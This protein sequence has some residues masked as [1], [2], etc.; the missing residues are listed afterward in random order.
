M[1]TLCWTSLGYKNH[2]SCKILPKFSSALHF[3][4]ESYKFVQESQ[5]LQICYNVEHF[6]H[7]SDNIFCKKCIFLVRN[8][9]KKC[10]LLIRPKLQKSSNYQQQQTQLPF[11]MHKLFHDPS[12]RLKIVNFE[13]EDFTCNFTPEI[14]ITYSSYE[15]PDKNSENSSANDD[16][17][18]NMI[19]IENTFQGGFLTVLTRTCCQLLSWRKSVK[20]LQ[21]HLCNVILKTIKTLIILA[22]FNHR[23]HFFSSPFQLVMR[24]LRME[25]IALSEALT[26][27]RALML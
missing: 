1:W 2:K 15:T 12:K 25:D 4:Q 13:Q 24:L 19:P 16:R 11:T 3:L 18:M 14:T 26:P 5:I 8:S 21:N 7:D 17:N 23:F 10:D 20:I 6:L 9:Y 27:R 22:K